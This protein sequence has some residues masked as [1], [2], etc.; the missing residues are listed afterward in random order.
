MGRFAPRSPGQFSSWAASDNP[1]VAG[2]R[3]VWRPTD[4]ATWTDAKDFG[5]VTRATIP[6]VSKD[7]VVFGVQALSKRGHASLATYPLPQSRR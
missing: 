2:Y 7:N 1:Q 4:S 3:V 5:L 6:R